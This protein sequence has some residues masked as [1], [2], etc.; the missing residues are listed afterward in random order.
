MALLP[1]YIPGRRRIKVIIIGGG[2]AGLTAL[3]TLKQ[4]STNVDIV[5]IDPNP[6]HLKITHLHET[7]RYPLTD[8]LMPFSQFESRFDCRHIQ[9]SLALDD[10]MIKQW[11][12]DKYLAVD[13]EILDF[14]Y[15]VIATG[16]DMPAMDAPENVYTLQHFMHTAGSELMLNH[17][18]TLAEPKPVISVVGAGAT[19][20]QFL[21]EIRQFFCRQKINARLRLINA[22]EQVLAQFPGGFDRYVQERLREL[23]IE[24]VSNKRYR[25]QTGQTILLQ[26]SQNKQTHELPSHMTLLFLGKK[27]E[28]L[29]RTNAFGQLTVDRETLPHVFAAGDCSVYQSVGSNVQSAQ[30]AVRKGKLIGRNILR[31]SGLLKLLEPYLHHDIGY[32]VN[33]GPADAVGWL[34][35]QGNIVTGLPALTIKEVVEAQYDLLLMGI[36][37]YVV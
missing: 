27:Q 36:D 4:Y 24:Y 29:R 14:D 3:T 7:F 11:Q 26:D 13:N 12:N 15:L 22:G 9:A 37:T 1:F 32:V 28:N 20:I 35:T 30:S 21:F 10:A 5:L 31:H 18:K 8:L 25:G 34:V 16:A 33:L 6:Q 2:Y 19:G 17:L 23:N